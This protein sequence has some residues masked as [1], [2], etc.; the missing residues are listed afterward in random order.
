MTAA[1]SL[2]R[3]TPSRDDT[4]EK[5]KRVGDRATIER[6]VAGLKESLAVD[7]VALAHVEDDIDAAL[8]ERGLAANEITPLSLRL[9]SAVAQLVDLVMQET[10]GR[11]QGKVAAAVLRSCHAL[12]EALP[13][14]GAEALG[15]LRRVALAAQDILDQDVID[16][17]VLDRAASL[18]GEAP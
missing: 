3:R 4:V 13:A 16:E 14:E 2:A 18:G 15:H 1:T 7:L 12:E 10:N 17:D 6:F 8:G 9:R 5:A 11:P